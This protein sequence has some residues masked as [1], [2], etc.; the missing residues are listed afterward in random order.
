M[1][2]TL[3]PFL[4][5]VISILLLVFVFEPQYTLMGKLQDQITQYK[6]AKD[7]Y[8]TFSSLLSDKIRQK[9]GHSPLDK[10]RL[11]RLVA[12]SIDDVRILVDIEAIA[13]T[14]GLLFGNI[15][16]SGSGV[17]RTQGSEKKEIGKRDELEAVDFSFEVI[18]T[19]AQFKDFLRDIES[20]LT[21]FET[22]KISL[23]ASEGNF[24][25][26][27]MTIRT[28]AHSNK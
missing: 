24:Q 19:Y 3:T 14:R 8:A 26:Y 23:S 7:Q 1:M 27:G 6:D 10:E 25:Q 20:S 16:I 28:Y 17:S 4:S 22:T 2:R 12:S 13:K 5:I 15:S 18:G 9:E 11:D 21:L